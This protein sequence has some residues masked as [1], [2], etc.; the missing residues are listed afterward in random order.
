[1]LRCREIDLKVVEALMEE[2]KK[3]Y[4]DKAKVAVPTITIDT[5]VHL[6]PPPSSED[7]H[8]PSWYSFPSSVFKSLILLNYANFDHIIYC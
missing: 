2:V 3:E 7:S 6:P 5:K 8:A 4:T 1:M